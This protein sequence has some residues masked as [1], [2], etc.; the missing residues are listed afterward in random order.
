MYQSDNYLYDNEID[1]YAVGDRDQ[2]LRR[3]ADGSL[4]IYVQHARPQGAKA[5]AN[6]LP[7]PAEAFH[8]IL[9]LYLPKRS[10]LNGHYRIP[11]FVRVARG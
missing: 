11:P 9:R 8:L 5:L 4:T 1:R 7:A 2:G 10:A 3:N 6:W